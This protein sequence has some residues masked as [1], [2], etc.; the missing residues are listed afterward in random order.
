[1]DRVE[2]F[3]NMCT[4]LPLPEEK[5]ERDEESVPELHKVAELRDSGNV[6]DAIEYATGLMKLHSDNDLVPFMIAYMYYQKELPDEAYQVAVE[7]MEKCPRKYRLYSAAGLAEFSRGRLPEAL[8][9]DPVL[10]P[11][12]RIDRAVI[13][14]T[15]N[16][17]S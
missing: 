14:A 13:D 5:D 7:A 6:H 17:A 4:T 8:L 15:G 16:S 2:Q 11:A 1:M 12:D 10:I 9:V 3:Y